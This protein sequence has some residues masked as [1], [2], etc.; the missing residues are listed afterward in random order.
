[1][2]LQ[3]LVFRRR[4]RRLLSACRPAEVRP[5]FYGY[6]LRDAICCG[7]HLSRQKLLLILN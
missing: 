1:M 7:E 3:D 4:F 2:S 6:R 5:L